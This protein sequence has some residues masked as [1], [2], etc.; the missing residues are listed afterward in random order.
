MEVS[1]VFFGRTYDEAMMLIGEA[2][3]FIAGTDAGRD[4]RMGLGDR[5]H[6]SCETMRLTTRLTQVMAWLLI[7]RAVHEGEISPV[8]AAADEH[9]LAGHEVCMDARGEE[10]HNLPSALRDLLNRSLRLFERVSRLDDQVFRQVQEEQ[11]ARV[12]ERRP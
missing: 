12:G 1:T 2:R 3:A 9:R 6:Y 11:A 5:L 8:D 4:P 10:N 7:Q